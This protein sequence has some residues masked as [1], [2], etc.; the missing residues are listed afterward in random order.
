VIAPRTRGGGFNDADLRYV[1]RALLALRDAQE[2]SDQAATWSTDPVVRA[3]ARRARTL[4]A[5]HIRELSST[6]E[7]WG[8]HEDGPEH[9]GALESSSPPAFAA[10][11]FSSL[12]RLELDRGLIESLIA[13]AR[14]AIASARTEMIEGFEPSIRRIA[15]DTIRA[16]NRDLSA[17]LPGT[18]ARS[19][20]DAAA[21]PAACLKHR[22]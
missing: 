18:S 3:L 22:A 16:N 17:I 19:R 20:Q 21:A 4:Q 10:T 14:G 12:D 9:T 15:E 7:K 5:D 8:R 13:H 6:L 2:A 1:R 11:C